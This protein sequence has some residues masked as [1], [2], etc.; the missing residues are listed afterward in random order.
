[1]ARRCTLAFL[2]LAACRLASSAGPGFPAMCPLEPAGEGH[3]VQ[4]ALKTFTA[5]SG[6]ASRGT[7]GLPQEVHVINLRGAAPDDAPVQVELHLKPIQSLLRHRKP[8]VFVLNS[9]GPLVWKVKT[10]NLVPGVPRTFHV[11]QGS[12]VRF[13][14]GNFSR[15]CQVHQELLP[16]GNQHLLTWT[17]KAYQALT[18][19]SEIR[20]TRDVYVKV[21]EDPVFSDTCKIDSRFLS[22]NYLGGY[23]QPQ[24]SKGCVL[25]ADHQ[26]QEV[27]IIEL[28][29][30]NS[31]SA[32]QVDVVVELRPQEDDAPLHRDVVLLLKCTKSVNWV[33]KSH[34]VVGK[35]SVVASDSVSV[36]A[37]TERRMQ[38]SKSPK[39]QL[40]PGPPALITWLQQH[41]YGAATSYTSTP[42]ANHF[43]VR[44]KEQGDHRHPD[45]ALPPELAILRQSGPASGG[46]LRRSG[47]PFPFPPPKSEGLPLPSLLDDRPWKAPSV[48]LA[49]HCEDA[50]MVVSISKDSLEANGFANASLT[51]QDP[52][53]KAEVNSTHHTL[54]TPLT[55]CLTT[56]YPLQGTTSALY[57]NTVLISHAESKD[58]SGGP[59]ESEDLESTEVFPRDAV[60]LDRPRGAGPDQL[61]IITF[62]CTYRHTRDS[63]DP[64]LG[65]GPGPGP[66]PGSVR[67][68]DMTFSMDLYHT[69]LAS[70]P[71]RQAFFTVSQD[72]Q[73]FVEVR[74]SSSD[75]GVG[76]TILS[77]MVS[78]DADPKGASSYTLIETVCPTDDSLHF[79]TGEQQ[80]DRKRFSFTFRSEV[81]ASPQFLHCKMSPCS[82]A[83]SAGLRLGLAPCLG[84]RQPCNSLDLD[85]ILTMMM[86]AKTTST[87][88]KLMDASSHPPHMTDLPTY[89]DPD[90]EVPDDP[91]NKNT[92][93]TPTVVIIAFAAF[94]I[95]ALLTGA[96]WFIYSHTGGRAAAVGG[97]QKC[98]PASDQSSTR[99]TRSTPCS[100]SSTA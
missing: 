78:P 91:A 85:H 21:G 23:V 15:S 86:G 73:V 59:L 69:P 84:P 5:L 87:A 43:D 47:P 42:L 97:A 51:L 29:A 36:S 99:S 41:N 60:D 35:L 40:P 30:P 32:F 81:K 16:H 95:G 72:Q 10:E 26:D 100:S 48:S 66:V 82:M 22:L 46:A 74:S 54:V 83:P 49:V 9:P 70:P 68:V 92:M 62:N 79:A 96:L 19:F 89:P 45:A 93:D 38:V 75:P 58:G 56:V 11:S 61:S 50:K 55:G 67:P 88:L 8:L 33:I 12:E 28:Q 39:Q 3:P 34:N 13:P 65:P 37:A 31:S 71:S 98:Q 25:S 44:L 1:M 2:L 18:S 24:P 27:H 77:C 63:Q 52:Q 14:P 6:C 80:V 53:C 64:G 17:L 90:P 20:M 76:F 4:A 94:A 7:A 57:I